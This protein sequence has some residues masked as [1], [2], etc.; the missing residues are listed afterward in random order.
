MR[1]VPLV[2]VL[3]LLASAVAADQSDPRLVGLFAQ[4]QAT[5]SAAEA[6]ELEQRIWA[7][8]FEYHGT[9]AVA[10]DALALGNAAMAAGQADLALPFFSR[11]VIAAPDFAEGWN[12]RAFA[13]FLLGDF[14]AAQADIDEALRLEPR[15]FGALAGLGNIME[16]LGRPERALAAYTQALAVNPHMQA[17][18]ERV[19]ALTVIV[20][21]RAI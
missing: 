5:A 1:L 3:A 6:A 18:R 19:Q 4:L 14:T 17:V 12:R 9:D 21:G 13:N 2:S 7:R 15:H 10:A 8:W 20:R 11:L 16:Q